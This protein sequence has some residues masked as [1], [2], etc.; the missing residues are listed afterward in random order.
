MGRRCP[1]PP[2]TGRPSA[3]GQPRLGGVFVVFAAALGGQQLA[4][5]QVLVVHLPS[6]TF[7][8]FRH[9]SGRGLVVDGPLSV[10]LG[11]APRICRLP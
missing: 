6:P 8:A 2:A 5:P 11:R 9:R 7:A 1:T 3:A 10:A 4:Q